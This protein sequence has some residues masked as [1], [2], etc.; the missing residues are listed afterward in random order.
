MWC[1]KSFFVPD[2]ITASARPGLRD[3]L[4]IT[5]LDERKCEI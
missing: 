2:L 1:S 4:Q 5:A 3:E